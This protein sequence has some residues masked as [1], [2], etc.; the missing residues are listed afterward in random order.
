MKRGNKKA[1]ELAISTIV[2]IVLAILVLIAVLVIFDRQT[3]IFSDFINNLMGK[4]N[5]DALVISCN[6]L[7][8]QNS[9]YDFCCVERKVKYKAEGKVLEEELT[10]NALADEDFVGGRIDKLNCEDVC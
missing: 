8:S 1:F 5:V 9:V 6:S 4:T 10:C 2:I 3:G 7:A